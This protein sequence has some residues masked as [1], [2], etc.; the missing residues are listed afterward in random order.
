[1][2][3]LRVDVDAPGVR[4]IAAKYQVTAMPT[5]IAFQEGNV[6]DSLKGADPRGLAVM[7]EKLKVAA[8]TLPAEAEKAKADGNKV[9]HFRYLAMNMLTSWIL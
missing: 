9:R 2:Q 7:V 5:F 3:F 4:A 6:V 1:M 8:T